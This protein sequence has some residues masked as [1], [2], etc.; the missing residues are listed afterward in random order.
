[1]ANTP[2]TSSQSVKIVRGNAA[3]I[4]M[5]MGGSSVLGSY[6][7]QGGRQFHVGW[8]RNIALAPSGCC[9]HTVGV[10]LFTIMLGLSLLLSACGGNQ[11]N[12]FSIALYLTADGPQSALEDALV[13][14]AQQLAVESRGSEAAVTISLIQAAASPNRWDAELEE[15]ARQQRYN[16]IVGRGAELGQV[17]YQIAPRWPRQSFLLLD[18]PPALL[19]TRVAN[20]RAIYFNYHEIGFL[21]GTMAALLQRSL[22]TELLP[23]PVEYEAQI[24]FIGINTSHISELRSSLLFGSQAILPLTTVKHYSLSPEHHETHARQVVESIAAEDIQVIVTVGQDIAS[25]VSEARRHK[26]YLIALASPHIKRRSIYATIGVEWE[27]VAYEEMR[28]LASSGDI[29]G[30]VAQVG[31][32]EGYLSVVY[33][34]WHRLRLIPTETYMAT[35]KIIARLRSGDLNLP[36]PQ[37]SGI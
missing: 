22:T 8:P 36:P 15:I 6:P 23:T 12:N 24:A 17:M 4:H 30:S 21:A 37:R 28:R 25:I 27:Q 1:M 31:S 29:L 26:M 32:R 5:L 19:P 18:A 16:L 9:Y 7:S 33:P 10:R 34:R 14:A 20:V 2:A 11:D 3:I 13:N 35:Q